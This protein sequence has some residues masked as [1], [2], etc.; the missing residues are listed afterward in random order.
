MELFGAI[1]VAL[2]VAVMAINH[3]N[4]RYEKNKKRADGDGPSADS[5]VEA[6][7]DEFGGDEPQALLRRTIERLAKDVKIEKLSSKSVVIQ[8]A[9]MSARAERY[10]LLPLLAERA[11]EIDEGCGETRTLRALA[12]AHTGN[13]F[14]K[15]VEAIQHAQSAAEGCAKCSSSIESKLLAEELAIAADGLKDRFEAEEAARKPSGP[16]PRGAVA[17]PSSPHGSLAVR[18]VRK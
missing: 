8:F 11:E 9:V 15:A 18:V 2:L 3:I 5:L 1:V 4:A 16:A 17:N 10:D 13:D 12:E 6:A 14:D 7:W